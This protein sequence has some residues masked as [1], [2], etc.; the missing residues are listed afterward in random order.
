VVWWA[1]RHALDAGLTVIVVTGA[2]P[3]AGVIP[4]G[5]ILIANPQWADGQ[6]TSLAVGVAEATRR[7]AG[8]I[9]V[10]LGDQPEVPTNAW[11]SMAAAAVNADK[12]IAVATYEGV[13]GQPVALGAAVFSMLP[14]DGDE[15]ARTLI[16]VSP[17]LVMEVPC[18]GSARQLTDIDLPRD[19]DSWN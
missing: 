1:V 11:V 13:R 2:V 6:S 9:I 17:H 16:R 14:Q 3:L 12:P 10:G 19:L 18:A 15:G 4:D 5:A 8:A 7:H